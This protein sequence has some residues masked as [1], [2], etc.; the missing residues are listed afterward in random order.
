[1]N[2]PERF[3][4]I[5]ELE[6]WPKES[7]QPNPS[8]AEIFEDIYR[9]NRWGS[10]ESRSGSGSELRTTETLREELPKLLRYLN[11]KAMLDLPCGDYNWMSEVD[12]SGI[13]YRGA[14]I[15][16][17]LIYDNRNK[18]PGVSFHTLDALEYQLPEFDLI[19]MRDMLVHFPYTDIWKCLR[20]MKASGSRLLMTTTFTGLR[21]NRDIKM[22][23]WRPLNLM[24][25]PFNLRPVALLNERCIE[26][27]GHYSDKCLVVFELKDIPYV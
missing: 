7:A 4:H 24:I 11:V 3:K 21:E 17:D 27:G 16:D 5:Y 18:F 8:P 13:I 12:L 15:V 25:E 26:G 14:D 19:L 1:M 6:L 20:N 22:G 10:S 2:I 9:N 23:G